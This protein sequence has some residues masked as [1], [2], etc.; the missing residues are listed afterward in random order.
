M[1]QKTKNIFFN[2]CILLSTLLLMLLLFG[3]QL[4]SNA[5][6]QV[7]GRMH[8]LMLHFP[9]VLLLVAFTWELATARTNNS[10]LQNAGDWL[11]LA[12]ALTSLIAAL[13]GILLSQEEGYNSNSLSLHKWSGAI[14]ALVA[15][16]W[17]ALRN[18]LRKKKSGILLVGLCTVA[19]IIFTGH[20][21]ATI[22][23]GESFLFPA[24]AKKEQAIAVSPEEAVAFTHL[25]KPIL[26]AKCISCHNNTKAKGDLIMET[27]ALLLKGGKNGKLWDSSAANFGLLMQRIHLPLE[28]KKHMPPKGKIQLTDDEIAVIHQWIKG[29]ANFT[30]RVMEYAETDSLR[31]LASAFLKSPSTTEAYNFAA[32]SET[33]IQ[34][35]NTDYRIIHP[36]ALQ[37][38]ALS[39]SF[40]GSSFFKAEHLKELKPIKDNIV[41]LHLANMPLKDADLD[42]IAGFKNLRTL[43]ISFTQ[44]TGKNLAQLIKLPALKQLSLTGLKITA[45]EV[46]VLK[47]NRSLSSIYIWNTGLSEAD[48]TALRNKIPS[49]LF[50]AGFKSDTVVASLN[51]PIIEDTKQIFTDTMQV[52][53]KHYIKGA[54]M[55]YTI[56]GTDP[57]STKSSVYTG[58][59]VLTKPGILKAK[60]FLP[61]WISSTIA[62]KEYY[63]TGYLADS[64][65]LLTAPSPTYKGNGGKTLINQET[66][67]MDFRNGKWLGYIKNDMQAILYFKQPVTLSSVS[68]S[69]IVDI[70]NY[71]MPAYQLEVWGGTTTANLK[72][73]KRMN[74]KQPSVQ[75]LPYLTG[76]NCQFP[77][78][79]VNVVKLIARPVAILPPWHRGSGTPGWVFVDEV[80]LN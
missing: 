54:I 74:P 44:V 80:F 39:V 66:G 34:K 4:K 8:P 64:V 6:L 49:V 31:L 12:A 67:E 36:I 5:F 40:Y 1:Q 16:L 32:A 46:E 7:L 14:I 23:H 60:A 33:T 65:Q 30:K 69:T 9:I 56:D 68:F 45:A 29:G 79:N 26:E 2:T 15:L 50:D 13:M 42:V 72:L 47:A 43:N 25:I 48:I 35:L 52:Q 37:S 70:G 73:L 24:A 27:E 53:L 28:E 62:S 19:G 77:A 51:A 75:L 17:Y 59:I 55:R 58:K 78:T 18:F 63:K 71:I 10:V 21:G 57:D 20:Q 22:T 3:N 61:G 76:F 11:L 38:P 41:T